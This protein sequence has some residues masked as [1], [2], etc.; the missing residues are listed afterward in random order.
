MNT[1]TFAQESRNLLMDGVAKKLLY[2]GFDTKGNVLEQPN[3]LSGGYTF[4]G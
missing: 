2:W 3:K 1:K 4:R